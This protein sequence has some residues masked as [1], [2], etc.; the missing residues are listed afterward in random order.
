MAVQIMLG[1]QSP[2]ANLK[3]AINSLQANGP[4]VTITARLA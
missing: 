2:R 4:I 3:N 1:P